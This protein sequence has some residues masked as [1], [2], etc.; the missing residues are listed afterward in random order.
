MRRSVAAAASVAWLV[1]V[2]GTFGC[3]LPYLMN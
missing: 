3:L 1:A 2:G